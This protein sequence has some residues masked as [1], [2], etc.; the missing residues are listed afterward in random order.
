MGERLFNVNVLSATHRIQRDYKVGMVRCND[1]N[2]INIIP[3]SIQHHAK[4]VKPSNIGERGQ[5]LALARSE[6]W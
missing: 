5:R 1:G 2:S 4:I 6:L 3:H